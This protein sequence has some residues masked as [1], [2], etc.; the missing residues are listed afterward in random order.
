[1]KNG[2]LLL[3]VADVNKKVVYS[4]L[5]NLRLIL[6]KNLNLINEKERNFLWVINAPLLE[7]SEEEKRYVSVH[8]PFTMPNPDDVH[9]LETEPEKVTS[10]TYDL[11]LN[12]NEIAGG[13]IRIHDMEVQKQVFKQLG[14]NEDEMQSQFGFLLEAYRYGAP[15]HGGIAF[16]FARMVMLLQECS[17]IRDVIAFPKTTSGGC[18]LSNAPSPVSERQLDELKLQIRNKK[19]I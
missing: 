3:F 19:R 15:P 2:D 12:G 17:S 14:F 10:L 7:Y 11:V 1:L 5:A 13:S 9:L 4:S 6:G 8:H 18:L 16:G